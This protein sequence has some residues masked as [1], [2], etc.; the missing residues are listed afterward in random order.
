MNDRNSIIERVKKLLALASSSNENEAKLAAGQATT[1]IQKFNI[2]ASELDRGVVIEFDL[3][4]GRSRISHWQSLLLRVIAKS[5]F[6]SILIAKRGDGTKVEV[7][8]RIVGRDVNVFATNLMYQY[9]CG[10]ASSLSPKILSEKTPYL[11]GFAYGIAIRLSKRNELWG[12]AEKN[13]LIRVKSE[14]EVAIDKYLESKYPDIRTAPTKQ[15]KMDQDS[16]R[17]GLEQSQKVNLSK[18][19]NPKHLELN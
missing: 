10:V 5:S 3:K 7:V 11:E 9:L 14:D 13:A 8:Y 17:Q 6:C 2:E 19:I 4:T 15:V 1:L 12:A 18:Q 16:F